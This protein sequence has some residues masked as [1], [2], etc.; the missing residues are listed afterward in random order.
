MAIIALYNIKG[1]VGKTA[2]AVNLSF[3]AARDGA[4]TLLCDLDPQGSA[5]YY[6]RVRPSK[7]LNKKALLKGGK[8]IDDNIKGTDHDNL[9]LLP[10]KLSF[11]NLDIA[12][13]NLKKSRR[14]LSGI[15]RPLT[16]EYQHI[17]LDC[18]PNITLVSENVFYAADLVLVP[19]IPTT[20]AMLSFEKL[21]KFFKDKK[22]PQKKLRPFFSMVELRKKMHREI[23]EQASA[24]ER[25][26]QTRIPYLA[27]IER[28]GIH[29]EPVMCYSGNSRAGKAYLQLWGETRVLLEKSRPSAK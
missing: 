10:A 9:D 7:K 26:F 18:P 13:D 2:T 12:L 21:R 23:V 25:F 27:D 24:N 16:R 3:L 6:L 29:R 14:R 20:L 19:V 5:T 22:L 1:G 8:Q 11:R 4:S 28:M 15:L 17:V